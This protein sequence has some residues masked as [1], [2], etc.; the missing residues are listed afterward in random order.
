MS[1]IL[2]AVEAKN[3]QKRQKDAAAKKQEQKRAAVLQ[4]SA[5]ASVKQKHLKV[6]GALLIRVLTALAAVAGLW[7]AMAFDLAKPVLVIPVICVVLMWASAWFGAWLQY[8]TGKEGLF[9]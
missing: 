2:E 8:I 7:I 5:K 4:A 9:K 6:L 1:D 3:V